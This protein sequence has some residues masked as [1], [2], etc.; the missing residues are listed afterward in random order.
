[1]SII[2]I[3]NVSMR[4][5]LSKERHESFKEYFLALA[6]GHLQCTSRPPERSRSTAPLRR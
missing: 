4:F 5:N 1:M 2:E 3:D 6:K